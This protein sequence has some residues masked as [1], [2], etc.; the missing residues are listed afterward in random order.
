MNILCDAHIVCL[1]IV[2]QDVVATTVPMSGEIISVVSQD[3]KRPWAWNSS[4]L[5]KQKFGKNL[6]LKVSKVTESWREIVDMI[7]Y[8]SLRSPVICIHSNNAMHG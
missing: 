7:K 2:R 3:H 4:I 5:E 6:S 8:S 1:H